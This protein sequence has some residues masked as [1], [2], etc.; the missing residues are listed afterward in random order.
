MFTEDCAL[1]LFILL[2][3]NNLFISQKRINKID[4]KKILRYC[5]SLAD[6]I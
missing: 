6:K 5:E 2:A 4:L 1:S 3:R